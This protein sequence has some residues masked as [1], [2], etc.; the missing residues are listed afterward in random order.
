MQDMRIEARM[1]P[2]HP[3]DLGI[4]ARGSLKQLDGLKKDPALLAGVKAWKEE[5][6]NGRVQREA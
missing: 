1:V 5:R 6:K 4:L 3:A 2:D